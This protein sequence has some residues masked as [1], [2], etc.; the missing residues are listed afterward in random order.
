MDELETLTPDQLAKLLFFEVTNYN[1]DVQY[2][3]DL[4][5]VGSPINHTFG[6]GQTALFSAVTYGNVEIVK[7]LISKG[8]DINAR[9]NDGQTAWDLAYKRIKELV[10]ELNPYT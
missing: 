5:A 10:P 9:N 2:I 1:S 8:A 4:I 6:I 7:L 3:Q